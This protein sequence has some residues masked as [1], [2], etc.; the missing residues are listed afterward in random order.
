MPGMGMKP[1]LEL[2]P[3]HALVTR[4]KDEA[5]TEAFADISELLL[6]EAMFVEGAK[7]EDPMSFVKLI[8]KYIK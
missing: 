6:L 5:D 4:L 1:I 2:N 7:I 8:N 3:E